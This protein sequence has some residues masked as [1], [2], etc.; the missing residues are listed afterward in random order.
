MAVKTE[1]ASYPSLFLPNEEELD[2]QLED[3]IEETSDE[4]NQLP[5]PPSRMHYME[6]SIP[7]WKT[8]YVNW[9]IFMSNGEYIVTKG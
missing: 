8:W 9:V 3:N 4:V 1:E 5:G 2:H 6:L 7:T